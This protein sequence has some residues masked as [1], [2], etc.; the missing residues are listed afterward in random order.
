MHQ[1]GNRRIITDSNDNINKHFIVGSVHVIGNGLPMTASVR[2]LQPIK[3]TETVS[4]YFINKKRYNFLQNYV[5]M[6]LL[7]LKDLADVKRCSLGRIG[8]DYLFINF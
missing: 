3:Q 4:W 8:S 7:V 2:D 5:I 1:S 6:T